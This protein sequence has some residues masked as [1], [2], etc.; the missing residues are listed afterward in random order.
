MGSLS[1]TGNIDF[2]LSPGGLAEQQVT[3]SSKLT[4]HKGYRESPIVHAGVWCAFRAWPWRKESHAE[5]N[6]SRFKIMAKSF[7]FTFFILFT[8]WKEN[9]IL[10]L[11]SIPNFFLVCLSP[12]GFSW[13]QGRHPKALHRLSLSL[14]CA[15]ALAQV[16]AWERYVGKNSNLGYRLLSSALQTNYAICMEK[17]KIG[18]SAAS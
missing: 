2:P 15:R 6:C 8:V 11:M 16:T 1:I 13:L 9:R 18:I 10:A 5:S 7:H 4:R 12:A 14:A 17:A 3:S